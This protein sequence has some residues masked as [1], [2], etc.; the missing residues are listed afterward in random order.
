[1]VGGRTDHLREPEPWFGEPAAE[2]ELVELGPPECDTLYRLLGSRWVVAVLR[3][4]GGDPVRYNTLHRRLDG[5]SHKVLTQTLRRLQRAGIVNRRDRA[6]TPRIVEYVLTT[7]G[8]E[9]LENL[10]NLERWAGA[11][12]LLA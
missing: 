5:V 10:D 12:G 4:L 11:R 1:M 7:A 3:Q 8:G 6:T 9:L 2:V